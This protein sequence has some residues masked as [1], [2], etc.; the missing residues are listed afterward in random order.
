VRSAQPTG[1]TGKGS[2]MTS[3]V[4]QAMIDA[5]FQFRDRQRLRTGLVNTGLKDIE[6]ETTTAPLEY[7]SGKVL[8]AIVRARVDACGVARLTSP[9]NIGI[10]ST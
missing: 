2:E 10:G 6:V 4:P 9:I 3:S 1:K 7:H 8:E 5:P